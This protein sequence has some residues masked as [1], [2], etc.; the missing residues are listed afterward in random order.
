M[1][2]VGAKIVINQFKDRG[3]FNGT[4]IITSIP[5]VKEEKHRVVL[6]AHWDSKSSNKYRSFTFP[7]FLW[8]LIIGDIISIGGA[9]LRKYV[10][11]GEKWST[12]FLIILGIL[13]GGEII[14]NLGYLIIN[15]LGN[16]SPGSNDNASGVAALLD[17]YEKYVGAGLQ[18]TTLQFGFFDAE[19]IGLQGS[20]AFYKVYQK[21][22]HQK[23]AY[24]INL[25]MIAG[26]F[27]LHIVTKCGIPALHHAKGMEWALKQVDQEFAEINTGS[28]DEGESSVLKMKFNA[29]LSEI[30]SDLA[31]FA[32]DGV[33]VVLLASYSP[34]HTEEDNLEGLN[35]E[36][37]TLAKQYIDKF[38]AVVDSA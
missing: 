10:A 31:P 34:Y 35:P 37:Y 15:P 25:D 11:I 7:L 38:L 18:H 13:V 17:F 19:E 20:M 9:F 33:P 21:E 1:N 16:K 3:P 29:K 14:G 28:T 23:K 22:L 27:P 5:S 12:L 4:N 6:T 32:Y 8:S 24:V 26:K 2:V 36:I 30:E